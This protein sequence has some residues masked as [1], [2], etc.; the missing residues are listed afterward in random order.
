[1]L[2]SS[3]YKSAMSGL[4]SGVLALIATLIIWSSYFVALRSGAQSSL[5]GYDMALLRFVLPGMLLIPVLIRANST[6]IQTPK[7]YLF[8]IACGAGLPFY[9]FSVMA[10]GEVQAVI[11]SLLVPGVS[12]VLVTVMAV[13]CYREKLAKNRVL[14]LSA[15]LVG[16]S[17]LVA[18]Q[19][20]LDTHYSFSERSLLGMGLYLCA[21]ACWA[22]Y[23]VSVRMAKLNGLEIAAVL[24]CSASVILGIAGATGEFTS[25]LAQEAWQTSLS[26]LLIMGVCCGLI[27]VITYGHAINRLGAELSACWGALTP[28]IVALLAYWVLGETV[29]FATASAMLL[30]ILGV[31]YANLKRA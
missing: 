21:A 29:T 7:R 12:P 22:V 3:T 30:I 25:H 9:L 15:V 6:I 8:G 17:V 5:T 11:G 23:T 14:G 27:T 24:N 1:M 18:N 26:Q 2:L 28:V 10:S 19:M 16:I 13:I 31:V 20:L 4:N